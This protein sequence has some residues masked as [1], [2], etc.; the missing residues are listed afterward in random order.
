MRDK[1]PSSE[2]RVVG[3]FEIPWI[4]GFDYSLDLPV[5]RS[6]AVELRVRRVEG[7]A[8]SVRVQIVQPSEECLH[9]CVLDLFVVEYGDELDAAVGQIA[10]DAE[11]LDRV[12]KPEIAVVLGSCSSSSR[13]A[14]GLPLRCDLLLEEVKASVYN[15]MKAELIVRAVRSDVKRVVVLAQDGHARHCHDARARQAHS[16]GL[17]AQALFIGTIESSTITNLIPT[18]YILVGA[19]TLTGHSSPF[20][21]TEYE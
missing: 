14:G 10:V 15:E 21:P 12:E 16:W 8:H 13:G 20:R 7:V 9:L 5:E 1:Y 18:W 2:C 17:A 19:G 4:P 11:F 6:A 3:W